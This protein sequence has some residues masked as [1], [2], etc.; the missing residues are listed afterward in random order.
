MLVRRDIRIRRDEFAVLDSSFAQMSERAVPFVTVIVPTHNRSRSLE[1]CLRTLAGQDYE[2]GRWEVIVADDASSDD[3]QAVIGRLTGAM[4]LRFVR[5]AERQ[6]SGPARNTA[7]ARA[8]GD[9]VLFLDSDTLAPPWL[10]GEHARSHRS[11]RR[12]VNGPAI[13]L[14]GDEPAGGWRFDSL[15]ARAL[16]RLDL[17]GSRFVTVNVSCPRDELLAAGAFDPAFG[18]R[19]G[20]EDTELGVRLRRRG[21][22]AGKNRRAFV[23]HRAVSG[24]DWRE[25]GRKQREAGEN[26]AY[27]LAKHPTREVAKLVRGRPTLAR[28]LSACG[29]DETRVAR[30][31]AARTRGGPL[32][33]AL[34]QAYEI[35][36]YERGLRRGRDARRAAT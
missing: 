33:W 13:N 18:P 36:Q 35:G 15:W 4:P 12:F 14:S 31:C 16:A 1:A 26:A 22:E 32:A 27:F 29:L 17:A 19:Y 7:L 5:H 3:T 34:H 6:G 11:G 20:W 28:A 2:D 23:L 9:L 24:Y 8:R 25:R 10:L 21:V 30:A